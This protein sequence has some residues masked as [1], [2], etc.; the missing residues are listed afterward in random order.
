MTYDVNYIGLNVTEF[1]S[2][3]CLVGMNLSKPKSGALI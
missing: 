2:H 1:N 3:A